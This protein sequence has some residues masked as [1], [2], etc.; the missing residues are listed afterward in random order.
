MSLCVSVSVYRSVIGWQPIKGAPRLHPTVPRLGSRNPVTLKGKKL[1]K[2]IDRWIYPERI[3][4]PIN[5]KLYNFQGIP[6]QPK[7]KPNLQLKVRLKTL[8]SL[9]PEP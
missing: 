9:Q 4:G 3:K 6:E 1:M 5:M 7:L 8:K 2:K